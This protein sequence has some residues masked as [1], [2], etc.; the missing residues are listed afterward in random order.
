[1]SAFFKFSL[2]HQATG[3]APV[4]DV[5]IS[6]EASLYDLKLQISTMSQ[7]SLKISSLRNLLASTESIFLTAKRKASFRPLRGDAH[8]LTERLKATL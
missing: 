8:C 5:E 7:V 6:Q 4:G 1:M 2:V 3:L